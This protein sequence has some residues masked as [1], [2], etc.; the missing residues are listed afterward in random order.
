MTTG[1]PH[2]PAPPPLQKTHAKSMRK[3]MAPAERRLWKALRRHIVLRD[4][5][6]R[7]QVSLGP[8]IVDFCCLPARLVIEADGN[9]HGEDNAEAYDS[10]RTANLENQG[11]RVLRFTNDDILRHV[12]EVIDTIIAALAEKPF[13]MDSSPP[14]PSPS[15][16]GG[17]ESRGPH[18]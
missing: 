8:Y 9:Q 2:F 14:T 3:E 18:A 17:G 13:V 11:F 16:R 12:D 4:T 10:R 6:F 7:R 5:H 15:P 1:R